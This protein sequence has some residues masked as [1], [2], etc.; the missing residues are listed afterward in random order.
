MARRT[1]RLIAGMLPILTSVVVALMLA[2]P[3]GPVSD[4][5]AAP[6]NEV[7]FAGWGGAT[8]D[9]MREVFFKPFEKAT[10]IRVVD[11]PGVNLA[12][13]Q[14]MVETRNVEWDVIHCLGMWVPQGTRL[15]LWENLEYSDIDR[16]GFRDYMATPTGIANL[17]NGIIL[18]YNT[19]MFPKSREPQT[20]ADFWDVKKFPGRRGMLNAP[21]YTLEF[22]LLADGVAK[23]KLYPLDVERAFRSLDRMKPHVNIWWSQWP[24]PP[25]L[26][27]TGEIGMSLTSNGRIVI[28]QQKDKVPVEIQ[29]NQGLLTVD[30]LAVPKGSPRRES[31][32][33]LVA[34]LMKPELQAEFARQTLIAPSNQQALKYLDED[35]RRKLPTNYLDK[36]V[37]LDNA[38][39]ADNI[40]K[41]TERWNEWR[42]K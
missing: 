7:V 21:R 42:L 26:L 12:K 11:V 15:G 18:A 28:A 22:A 25:L 39:W 16:S 13:I 31:A 38:W 20:W 37:V 27:A 8:Q 19:Q 30:Y 17:L 34:W 36:M 41:M 35:T 23:D 29:W 2:V 5:V 10:G 1:D 4:G 14:S 6:A 24:Q 9:T 40:D 3:A 32:M 33:K